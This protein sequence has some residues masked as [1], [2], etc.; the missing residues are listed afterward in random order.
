MSSLPVSYFGRYIGKFISRVE[1]QFKFPLF[2]AIVNQ[3]CI[4]YVCATSSILCTL[5]SIIP[6]QLKKRS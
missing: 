3:E 6:F 2:I 4:T 1:F 5:S